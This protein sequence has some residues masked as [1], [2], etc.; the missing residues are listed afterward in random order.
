L[1][2]YSTA[3]LHKSCEEPERE[4]NL[5]LYSKF[6]GGKLCFPPPIKIVSS[7]KKWLYLVCNCTIGKFMFMIDVFMI[8][9]GKLKIL[10]CRVVV[11]FFFWGGGGGGFWDGEEKVL[12]YTWK[13][14]RN[15]VLVTV[16]GVKLCIVCM[17]SNCLR[18]TKE[19]YIDPDINTREIY[20]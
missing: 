7:G 3:A 11:V 6:F 9:L 15:K 1:L 13:N 5:Y 14:Y 20:V 19:G 16:M 10:R 2:S 18:D 4:S 8:K 12:L 17:S